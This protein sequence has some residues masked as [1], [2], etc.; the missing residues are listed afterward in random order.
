MM[1]AVDSSIL[2]DVFG[3]DPEYVLGPATRCGRPWLR[4]A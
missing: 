3:A 1:T 4:V 2:L